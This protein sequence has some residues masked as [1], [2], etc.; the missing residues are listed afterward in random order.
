MVMINGSVTKIEFGFAEIAP[1]IVDREQ[2][3]TRETGEPWARAESRVK[4]R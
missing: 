4:G 2:E 3:A 1:P